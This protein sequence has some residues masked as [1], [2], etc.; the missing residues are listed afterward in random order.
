MRNRTFTLS[1]ENNRL[2]ET[3]CEK[4]LGVNFQNDLKWNTHIKTVCHTVS[5]FL[6]LLSK[7][8]DYLSTEYRKLFYSAYI[9]PHMDY[10]SLLWENTTAKNIR[11]VMKMQKRAC[12]I[13]LGPDYSDFDSS[14]ERLEIHVTAPIT[15]MF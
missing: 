10:C 8:K 14:V 11:K 2:E 9:Q 15:N 6:W 7:I 13:I 12:K 5:S 3:T 1:Y 4:I